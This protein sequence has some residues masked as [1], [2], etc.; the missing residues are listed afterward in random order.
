VQLLWKNRRS[1]ASVLFRS[2]DG[3]AYDVAVL[4]AG[5]G[6]ELRAVNV[7]SNVA[8]KGKSPVVMVK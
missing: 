3:L 1:T 8:V 2:K 4:R 6:L 7:S 5:P